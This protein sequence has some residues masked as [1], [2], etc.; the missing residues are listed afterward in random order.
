VAEPPGDRAESAAEKAFKRRFGGKDKGRNK[1]EDYALDLFHEARATLGHDVARVDHALRELARLYN[2]LADGPIVDLP[3][4]TRIMALL[5]EGRQGEA[6]ALLE[7]RYRL[8][9]PVDD[10]ERHG[11][12]SPGI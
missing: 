3:T 9:A 2:P 6:G 11:P 1:H 8:Y 7:E 4:R 12:S 5:S 10:A